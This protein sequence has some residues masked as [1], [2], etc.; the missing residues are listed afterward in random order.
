MWTMVF[1]PAISPTESFS[2]PSGC[3]AQFAAAIEEFYFSEKLYESSDRPNRRL[4]AAESGRAI[5]NNIIHGH[6]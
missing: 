2:R 4:A 1:K 3:R 5:Q 6:E